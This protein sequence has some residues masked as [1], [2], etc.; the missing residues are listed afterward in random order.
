MPG[1]VLAT[2]LGRGRLLLALN[3]A[4]KVGGVP[5][6]GIPTSRHMHK[7]VAPVDLPDGDLPDGDLPVDLTDGARRGT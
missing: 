1:E 7:R 4:R 6:S 2:L 5:G 3:A